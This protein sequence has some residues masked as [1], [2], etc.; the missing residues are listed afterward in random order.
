MLWA[1]KPSHQ[2]GISLRKGMAYVI[3]RGV[4]ECDV[5]ENVDGH[6]WRGTLRVLRTGAPAG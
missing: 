6:K 1:C 2:S 4:V 3:E 5:R